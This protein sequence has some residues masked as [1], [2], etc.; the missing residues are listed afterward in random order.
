MS[1]YFQKTE[2]FG[3]QKMDSNFLFKK[4]F[5]IRI[6]KPHFNM[7]NIH[8]LTKKVFKKADLGHRHAIIKVKG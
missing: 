5:E 1:V 6:E 4:I 7:K 2:S 8:L 3:Q